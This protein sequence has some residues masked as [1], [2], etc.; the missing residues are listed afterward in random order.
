VAVST[1]AR[2]DETTP[3]APRRRRVPL[4]PGQRGSGLVAAVAMAAVVL[5]VVAA[6]ALVRWLPSLVNPFAGRE[7][8]RSQPSVLLALDDLSEYHAATGQFQVIIDVERDSRLPTF[9]HGE[10]TLFVAGG[11]VDAIVDFERLGPDAVQV[12]SERAVT[13]TLP[14]ARLS[15]ARVDPERSY[16]YERDRGLLD[17]VGGAFSDSPTSER[18]LYLLAQ[19][20]LEA[21]AAETGLATRAEDNTREMLETMLGAVGFDEVTVRFV[22]SA[23]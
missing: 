13:L 15:D 18:D 6:V 10:R 22:P 1:P 16:V 20:K 12:S 5:L 7:I 11:T 14:P 23:G 19:E 9:L 21:A 8:D 4:R 17:R 3:A 2:S